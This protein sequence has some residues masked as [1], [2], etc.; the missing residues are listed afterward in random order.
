M[1]RISLL[2]LFAIGS[3]LLLPACGGE[4]AAAAEQEDGGNSI[5][6]KTEGE[7]GESVDININNTEDLSE[8]LNQVADALNNNSEGEEVEVMN[9]RDIKET[10][11]KRL[12]GMDR[13]KHQG[14]TTGAMGFKISQAEA[15]YEDGDKSIDVMIVDSGNM[16]FAKLG[17]AAWAM[18]EIDKESDEGYERTLQIDGHKAYE[19]WNANT[20]K[21]ELSLFYKERYIV[22]LEGRGLE[23]DDLHKALKRLDLDELE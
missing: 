8:A 1:N 6:I 23:M 9:F 11:P 3:L 20:G 10:M 4:E 12:L 15:R 13:E 22:N 18:V 21:G 17:T 16:G 2:F 7:N 19:K 5:T 14:E